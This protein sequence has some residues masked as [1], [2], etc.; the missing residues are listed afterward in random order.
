MILKFHFH[1]RVNGSIVFLHFLTAFVAFASFFLLLFSEF[2]LNV[3]SFLG[4]ILVIPAFLII[5]SA[6]SSLRSQTFVPSRF[7]VRKGIYS[8]VRNPMYLGIILLAFGGFFFSF[9]VYTL[10]YALILT[11]SYLFVIRAEENDLFRR[12]G[13]SYDDYRRKVPSLIPKL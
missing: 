9:S 8:R 2:S 11:V 6:A 12:F 13:R 7:L 4:L 3:F 5:Y 1:V 10:L